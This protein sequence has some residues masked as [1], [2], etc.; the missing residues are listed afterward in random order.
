M[1]GTKLTRPAFQPIHAGNL[2]VCQAVT[3]DEIGAAQALRYRVFYQEMD[4]VPNAEISALKRDFDQFDAI[5]DHLLVVNRDRLDEDGGVIG[6]YRVLR[7]SVA[8]LHNGFY[9]SSEYDITPL[10]GLEGEIMEL[11]RS[12][13]DLEFRTRP[14]MQLLWKAIAAYVFEHDVQMMFGC[15]SLPGVDPRNLGES[16]SYLHYYHA[17][18]E[19][20]CPR[21][22]PGR[23]VEMNA[24]PKDQIDARRALADLPPLIKGYLRLGG[25]VGDGAVIDHQFNTTDV[26]VMVRTDLV[27]EKYFKHYER[28]AQP[29]AAN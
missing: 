28:T 5:C 6:T 27:S 22:L 14:T 10:L 26:C 21:A 16:L 2:T 17:A 4:A 18:P 7:R 29:P 15:A 23:Y 25:V 24:L 3:D 9:S 11:G 19:E 12:C 13:V 1:A 8:D 20:F